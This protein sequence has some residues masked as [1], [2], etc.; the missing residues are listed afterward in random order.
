MWEEG[1]GSVVGNEGGGCYQKQSD[2]RSKN[3][4]GLQGEENENDGLIAMSAD[5][6]HAFWSWKGETFGLIKKSR[7]R[8]ARMGKASVRQTWNGAS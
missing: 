4:S 5:I 3:W 7:L 6:V 8:G 2:A 1:G